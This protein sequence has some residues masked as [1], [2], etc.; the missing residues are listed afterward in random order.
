MFNETARGLAEIGQGY[1]E[2]A[3]INMKTL[4]LRARDVHNGNI[5]FAQNYYKN[6]HSTF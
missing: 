1:S 6:F 3:S 5:F 2:A 4:I